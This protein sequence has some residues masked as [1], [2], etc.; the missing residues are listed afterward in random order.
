MGSV[1]MGK[2]GHCDK[3]DQKGRMP[4]Q[5]PQH[6]AKEHPVPGQVGGQGSV[7]IYQR[8][9]GVGWGEQFWPG[10]STLKQELG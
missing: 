6:K 1:S 2:A 8:R 10:I 3:A 7:P 4:P 9:W 5:V